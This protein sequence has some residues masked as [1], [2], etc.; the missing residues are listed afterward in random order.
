MNVYDFDNTIYDGETFI[1]LFMFLIKKDPSLIKYIPDVVSGL[2]KYTKGTINV[3][4]ALAEYGQLFSEYL[5]GIENLDELLSSFW[6][7]HMHKIKMFYFRQRQA[8][9]III[10]ASPDIFLFDILRRLNIKNYI[11][12][13]TDDK[14]YITDLCFR[15]RKV[16][17]FREKFPEAE[18]DNFYTDSVNDTPMMEIAKHAFLVSGNRITQVK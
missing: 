14:A 2:Y 18:I 13:K 6:D 3:D 11:C 17:L 15:G 10:S 8:D 4:E 9:D 5:S 1:S 7:S 16:E 12:S